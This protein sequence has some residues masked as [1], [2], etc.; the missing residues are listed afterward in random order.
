MKQLGVIMI[1]GND[2]GDSVEHYDV[3]SNECLD[4]K[5]E[6]FKKELANY[7]TRYFNVES[8]SF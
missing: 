1:G 4:K 6:E 3:C 8:S 5:Y 2:S 7:E